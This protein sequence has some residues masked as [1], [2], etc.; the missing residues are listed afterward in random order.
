MELEVKQ[1]GQGHGVN[2]WQVWSSKLAQFYF[3]A[4]FLC[5]FLSLR[6]SFVCLSVSL[7]THAH[8]HML[9]G[10]HAHMQ[11]C[12]HVCTQKKHRKHVRMLIVDGA[13][14]VIF[15]RLFY[16]FPTFYKEFML[17]KIHTMIFLYEYACFKVSRIQGFWCEATE[18]LTMGLLKNLLKNQTGKPEPLLLG[19]A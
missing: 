1:L 3:K 2:E 8:A 19:T 12:T 14:H 4:H 16:I 17:R 18:P 6:W 9:A 10:T 5:F 7:Q 11:V 15:N 13:V